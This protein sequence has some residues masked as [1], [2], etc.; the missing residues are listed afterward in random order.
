M[1]KSKIII[2]A[3]AL[4]GVSIAATTTGTLA[5][6]TA[7]NKAVVGVGNVVA[8]NASAA[9]K[10]TVTGN[11]SHGTGGTV[12]TNGT[13]SVAF[14]IEALR[15][16]SLDLKAGTEGH[17]GSIANVNSEGN[18]TGYTHLSDIGA[19]GT[20]DDDKEGSYASQYKVNNVTKNIY[21]YAE[22]DIKF[23]LSTAVNQKY[24]VFFDPI[25]SSFNING[26]TKTID[27]AVRVGLRNSTVLTKDSNYTY[28]LTKQA[29][30]NY[31]V[32]APSYDTVTDFDS[33][34]DGTQSNP[35]VNETTGLVYTTYA[36]DTTT[37]TGAGK[38][39]SAEVV[40]AKPGTDTTKLGYLGDLNALAAGVEEL[41]YHAYIWFDG[42]DLSC[43]SSQVQS[44][45]YSLSL[46]FYAEK[47]AA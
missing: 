40:T 37:T 29:L 19:S 15:D 6:F 35:V 43:V 47:A 18:I 27:S 12:T 1:K 45:A 26:D 2:G 22:F 28:T 20:I 41:V 11:V 21:Y 46:A 13:S 42:E 30:A 39:T 31:M 7:T 44:T 14:S 33:V 23:E 38:Y 17:L 36:Q 25:A 16:C 8:V 9:L 3:V 10:A 34:S 4:L 24:N 5:W 32:W